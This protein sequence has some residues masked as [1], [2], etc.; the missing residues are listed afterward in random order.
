MSHARQTIRTAITG[1]LTGLTTTGTNVFTNHVYPFE[2]ASLPNVSLYVAHEPETVEDDSEMGVYDLRVLPFMVTGRAKVSAN[3]DNVLDD[4][5]AEV[6]TALQGNA[7]LA[8]Y[9]KDLRLVGTEV[10]LDP[11]GEKEVGAI[12]MEWVAVYR[13]DRTAPTVPVQ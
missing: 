6:E 9:I 7:T 8:G 11:E 2:T 1:A 12:N 13:V 5:S 3:L 10:A 4:I